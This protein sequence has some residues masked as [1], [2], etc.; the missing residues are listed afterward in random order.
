MATDNMNAVI[1]ATI[2][3]EDRW[4]TVEETVHYT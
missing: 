2:L 4:M 1:V 3:D